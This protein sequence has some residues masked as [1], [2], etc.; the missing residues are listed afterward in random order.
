MM[1]IRYPPLR[2]LHEP[3]RYPEYE[4]SSTVA[5]YL[6]AVTRKAHSDGQGTGTADVAA[7]TAT[8]RNYND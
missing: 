2:A 7:A 8:N 3:M 4:P 5:H 1:L 6:L